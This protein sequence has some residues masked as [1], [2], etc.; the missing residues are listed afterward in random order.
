MRLAMVG[1][2][3]M[4]LRMASRL[5]HGGHE[6][7]AFDIQQEAVKAAEAL[8]A[9]GVSKIDDLATTLQTPR[10]VWMMVPAG[11]PTQATLQAIADRLS[12]GDI[13]IDGGNSFYRDSINA[14]T[15]LKE[16]GIH[17]VDVGT[18]GGIWGETEGYCMMVGGE[19]EDVE[20]LGPIF[21][22][23]APAADKGWGHVGPHGAGHF[24]K[25]VHNGIEYG[26]MEAYAEGFE[27]M[28]RKDDLGLKLQEIA[29]IWRYGSVIRSWLLDLAADALGDNPT[30]EGVAAIVPDSG[31]GRWTVVE[32]IDLGVPMPV[33]TASLERR[34]RSRDVS[35]FADKLL[36]VLRQRFGGHAVEPTET[37]ETQMNSDVNA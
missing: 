37:P 16:K 31:E 20:F 33:I 2:G 13:I 24:V 25:M 7:V 29:E 27:L 9:E 32:A 3:K 30:L 18:S 14:T 22:T 23:L 36:A 28:Q 19:A 34:F 17:F 26:L 6:V 12:P 4:G 1:M 15:I 10:V 5:M 35:P 11:A 21:E 8:G